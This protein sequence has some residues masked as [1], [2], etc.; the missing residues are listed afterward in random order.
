MATPFL[1]L[2]LG[3]GGRLGSYNFLR[4]DSVDMLALASEPLSGSLLD[5]QRGKVRKVL[6]CDDGHT[7]VIAG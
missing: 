2:A 1:A 5:R 6:F 4:L 7:V 3:L